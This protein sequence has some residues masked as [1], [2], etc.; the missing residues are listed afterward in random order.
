VFVQGLVR[1]E[2]RGQP[3][4]TFLGYNLVLFYLFIF[5]VLFC[6]FCFVCFV[7]FFQDRVSLCSPGCLETHFVDQ[8][9]LKLR[10]PPA[11]VSA[12][13]VLGLKACTTMPGLVLFY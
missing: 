8:V 13:Q 1:V 11:S 6:L 3:Q 2:A 12:S 7:L 5:L 9:G 10:N 4:G